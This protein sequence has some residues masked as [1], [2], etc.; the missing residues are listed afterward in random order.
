MIMSALCL[1]IIASLCMLLDH[2]GY[3]W[4]KLGVL[5]WV[6]RL[7]FPLYVYLLVNGYRHTGSRLR[8]ALRLGFCALLSQI[9][10][11]LLLRKE[12]LWSQGNVFFTLLLALLVLWATDQLAARRGLRFLAPLP[13]LLAYGLSFLGY[14]PVDYGAKGFLL[15][16]VFYYLEDRK[17]LCAL[18]MLCALFHSRFVSWGVELLRLLQGQT[19]HFTAL[20]DWQL[21]QL[22]ALLALPLIF[23]YNGKKGIAPA[24]PLGK[25]LLQWGFYLFY[26]LHMLILYLLA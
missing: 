26:P 11:A 7:A 6:G 8:Y 14:L 17:L 22:W 2:M 1:R 25:K 21:T 13:A 23:L 10:F 18:G 16:L 3:L 15:A 4:P 20:T 19:A 5:R 9:P 24:S 12:Q